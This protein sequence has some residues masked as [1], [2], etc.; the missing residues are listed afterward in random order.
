MDLL[1]QNEFVS[2]RA[3]TTALR[4]RG[5]WDAGTRGSKRGRWVR[6]W[7]NASGRE[8]VVPEPSRDGPNG[9]Y[10]DRSVFKLVV[11]Q[12]DTLDG[13][14]Y[15]NGIV[16]VEHRSGVTDLLSGSDVCS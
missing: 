3:L 5:Y 8:L 6:L 15:K 12:A 9:S 1:I 7:V 16:L 4:I 2:E 14:A 13:S 11:E 10:Y